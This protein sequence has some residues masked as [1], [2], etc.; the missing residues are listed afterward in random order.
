MPGDSP[1]RPD[2]SSAPPSATEM[3]DRKPCPVPPT[4]E[5]TDP[6][7]D[8]QGIAGWLAERPGRASLVK[9]LWNAYFNCCSCPSAR[10]E[11]AAS[12]RVA[13]LH[14]PATATAVM[15]VAALPGPA[16]P[17]LP[18][19]DGV[20]DA[21][22]YA[23]A[24]CCRT[25]PSPSWSEQW[26][27]GRRVES[28]PS[29]GTHPAPRSPAGGPTCGTPAHPPLGGRPVVNQR[30]GTAAR[31]RM[32][33]GPSTGGPQSERE[34]GYPWH[35]SRRCWTPTLRILAMSTEES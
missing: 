26:H 22:I 27:P 6:H 21:G 3:R 28:P 30:S 35:T 33:R 24:S 34:E 9:G 31:T 8:G 11:A 7:A 4:A 2:L 12:T 16:Q 13:N 25:G 19:P 17:R 20:G 29:R 10:H 18:V 23:V 5:P 1:C 15:T 14:S 32:R